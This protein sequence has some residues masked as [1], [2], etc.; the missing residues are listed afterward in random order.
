MSNGINNYYIFMN[1]LIA[2]LLTAGFFSSCSITPRYHSFGYN[3]EWKTPTA[4]RTKPTTSPRSAEAQE[5]SLGEAKA[6][7]KSQ[8][9]TPIAEKTLTRTISP[10]VSADTVP[11]VKVDTLPQTVATTMASDTAKQQLK[12][13]IAKN[14]QNIRRSNRAIIVDALTIPLSILIDELFYWGDGFLAIVY[15]ILFA[16][17]LLVILLLIRLFRGAKKRILQNIEKGQT[18]KSVKKIEAAQIWAIL[19]L[20]TVFPFFFSPIIFNII[21]SALFA[22]AKSLGV[23]PEYYK[24]KRQ[25][26]RIIYTLAYIVSISLLIAILF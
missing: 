11:A 2:F 20:V 14:K 12:S 22:R 7:F 15:S 18:P 23:D 6:N 13:D 10:G 3:V 8:Q 5:Q 17:P 16:I 21:S 25:S 4:Q 24:K 19:A 26:T 9:N 1:R